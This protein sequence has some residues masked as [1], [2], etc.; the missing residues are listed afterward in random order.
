[1]LVSSVLI[2]WSRAAMFCDSAE[3]P[4][5]ALRNSS[6]VFSVTEARVLSEL[7]SWSVSMRSD[8]EARPLNAWTTSYGEVVRDAGISEPSS[9]WPPPLG[10]SERYIAPSSVLTLIAAEVGATEVGAGV[11]EELHPHVVA[12]Q[13]DLLD[14]ADADAG[15]PDL[16]VGL[17]AAGL[18]R[19]RRSRCR[20]RR[21]AA[22]PR[23]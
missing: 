5:S 8:R 18:A 16:V 6:G 1:M 20:R 17:E 22:G 3:S 14:L 21:S 10:S 12:L 13:G 9:I 2:C 4:V 15:D 19:R 11:D 7:A 23:P